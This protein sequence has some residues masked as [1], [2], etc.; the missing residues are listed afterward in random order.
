MDNTLFKMFFVENPDLLKRLVAGMFDL[1]ADNI[2][3]FEIINPEIPP[4]KI[5]DEP[6]RWNINVLIDKKNVDLNVQV[7]EVD[8][9]NKYTVFNLMRR[10][11]STYELTEIYFSPPPIIDIYI[12]DYPVFDCDSYKLAFSLMDEGTREHVIDLTVLRYYEISKLPKVMAQ[13]TELE[14]LL[15]LFRART[16]KDLE[17][18]KNLG[19]PILNQAIEAY[20]ELVESAR[21]QET[22]RHRAESLRNE[23]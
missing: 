11:S 14:L 18:L 3:D 15:A 17:E 19:L 6:D 5:E 20:Y 8:D 23:A 4:E 2:K 21:Y 10:L 1:V 7:E 22:V 9:F 13:N 12:V 16:V